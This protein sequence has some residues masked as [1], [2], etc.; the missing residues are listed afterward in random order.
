MTV[1]NE[2]RYSFNCQ[3]EGI[4]KSKSGKI[5]PFYFQI[6]GLLLPDNDHL[7]EDTQLMLEQNF[8]G[9]LIYHDYGSF[10]QIYGVA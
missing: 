4:A 3:V 1:I 8:Q 2:T 6:F 9:K 5:H 7:A 10:R